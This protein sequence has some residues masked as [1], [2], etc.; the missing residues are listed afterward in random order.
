MKLSRTHLWSPSPTRVSFRKTSTLNYSLSLNEG[1]ALFQSTVHKYHNHSLSRLNFSHED[2][3]K[4]S[5]YSS[6]PTKSI[7][8]DMHCLHWILL[9][10]S[11]FW[12][13]RK[14]H[15][16]TCDCDPWFSF[17]NL[18]TCNV[19]SLCPIHWNVLYAN[20]QWCWFSMESKPQQLSLV[21][22]EKKSQ[23]ARS[24][25]R[26]CESKHALTHGAKTASP[27]IS[28]RA[29]RWCIWERQTGKINVTLN[30]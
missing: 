29:L 14:K 21:A 8:E 16:K 30:C 1:I 3:L 28:L 6:V 25:K 24:K 18:F 2:T 13:T 4:I 9:R 11:N 19:N 5:K 10:L 12:V 27:E 15:E 17:L 26:L 23:L 7:Q 20:W 22:Y